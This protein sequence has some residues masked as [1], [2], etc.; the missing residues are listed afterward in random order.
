[1]CIAF[2]VCAAFLQGVVG[3]SLSL[4][5]IPCLSFP[6]L[7]TIFCLPHS[8]HCLG[9]LSKVHDHTLIYI[10]QHS[11]GICPFCHL[12]QTP[13]KCP[14]LSWSV[15][16]ICPSLVS[17]ANFLTTVIRAAYTSKLLRK[18]TKRIGPRTGPCST[19]DKTFCHLDILLF[20]PPF[21]SPGQGTLLSN[22]MVFCHTMGT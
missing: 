14:G 11:P 15:L 18:A 2:A 19:P 8:R 9:S 3:S 7:L 22:A 16:T 12:V 4:T 21:V 1:M 13:L 10:K 17:S 5:L 20:K 6:S